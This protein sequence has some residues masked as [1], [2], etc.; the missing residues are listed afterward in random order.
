M[1]A[2]QAVTVARGKTFSAARRVYIARALSVLL[3][4]RVKL[5]D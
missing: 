5:S 1:R 4:L 3:P 2:S